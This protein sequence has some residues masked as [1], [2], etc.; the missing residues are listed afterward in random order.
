MGVVQAM[1]LG[2]SSWDSSTPARHV[3]DFG[4]DTSELAGVTQ[5]VD[6]DPWTLEPSALNPSGSEWLPAHPVHRV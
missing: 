4:E 1:Y 6:K 2:F 5:D 3:T